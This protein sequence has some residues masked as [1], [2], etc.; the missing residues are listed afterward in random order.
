MSESLPGRRVRDLLI[1]QVFSASLA[2]AAMLLFWVQPLMGKKLLP[3]FGGAP[4]VWNTCLVFFQGCLLLGYLYAHLQAKFV[5]PR[6]QVGAHLALMVIGW[7]CLQ[8][9]LPATST[10]AEVSYPTAS[11][12]RLLTFTVG[13]P[14]IILSATAPLLQVW[15][16][17]TSATGGP[18][19]LYAASSMGSLVGL[20]G[21]PLIM[22]P[23]LT[24]IS[25]GQA[26]S[27]A[28]LGTTVLIAIAG[29]LVRAWELPSLHNHHDREGLPPHLKVTAPHPK[30]SVDGQNQSISQEFSEGGPGDNPF[31]KGFPPEDLLTKGSSPSSHTP[32]SQW[33]RWVVYA[34]VPSSMLQSVTT[35]LTTDIAAVPLL[36]VAPLSVY[37]WSF[38]LVFSRRPL[39]PHAVVSSWTP[40][41]LVVVV[42]TVHWMGVKNI[43]LL[44]PV[45]L[46]G[47]FAVSMACHG[48]LF[49]MRPEE[50]RLTVFYL[51][52][53]AGGVLG[54]LFNVLAAPILFTGIVEYPLGMVIAGFLVPTNHRHIRDRFQP[55]LDFLLPVVLLFALTLALH[56]AKTHTPDSLHAVSL[57]I[58]FVG[59]VG[60]YMCRA[61]SVRFALGLAALIIGGACAGLVT[62]NQAQ[63]M[64]YAQRN[65]FGV[66]Q[67]RVNRTLDRYELIHGNTMHGGQSRSI[68]RSREPDAYFVREGPVG[69]VF[70]CAHRTRTGLRVAVAGLGAGTLAA[71]GRPGDHWAFFE[72]DP[73]VLKLARNTE[74]FTYLSQC[75]ARVETVLGD[76]RLKL[77][78]APAHFF[79][80]IVLDAFSSDSIPVHL[81][82]REALD[83]YLAKLAPDGILVFHT[84][85]RY[86]GLSGIL[87]SLGEDRNLAVLGGETRFISTR[88]LKS[89]ALPS[90]W[91]VMAMQP[92]RLACLRRKNHWYAPPRDRAAVPWSDDYSVVLPCLKLWP[93]FGR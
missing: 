25:Q 14:C 31:S 8:I 73:A 19:F 10:S 43:L 68:S 26:W 88:E 57:V 12:L 45:D 1:G 4:A 60:V 70:E 20:L 28:Y 9:S 64:L 65:F 59:G 42:V 86:L 85:N 29:L 78:E 90:T 48:E 51:C 30:H 92:E 80:V 82:T 11:L 84:T 77:A 79:D 53:A 27:F 72:I 66:L 52:I 91:V 67:V 34:A 16:A 35:H 63:E 41:V 75:P 36:W 93:E 24:L 33:W 13:L 55:I 87:A 15:Y 56:A 17:R 58:G 83:T 7:S 81:L 49:G 76:A 54:G 38:V 46:A 44:V 5:G 18:Y 61:R 89:G 22:E 47:L 21:Y 6:F 39:F 3:W 69:D 71:Y 50:H 23:N 62:G 37:L 74:Y 32:V 2:A 40:L